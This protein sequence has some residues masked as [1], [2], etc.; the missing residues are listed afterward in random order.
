MRAES[1]HWQDHWRSP[2]RGFTQS[3]EA[4]APGARQAVLGAE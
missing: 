4:P 3:F 2:D 1:L